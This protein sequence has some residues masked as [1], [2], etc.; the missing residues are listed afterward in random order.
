MSSR[1]K[2]THVQENTKSFGTKERGREKTHKAFRIHFTLDSCLFLSLSLR[3]SMY[4]YVLQCTHTHTHSAAMVCFQ[5]TYIF[6]IARTT[7]ATGCREKKRSDIAFCLNRERERG[8]ENRILPG[9]ILSFHIIFCRCMY[10]T[11]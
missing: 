7:I 9:A 10:L 8:W 3:F 6:V 5:C 1:N 2:W 4:V 11:A